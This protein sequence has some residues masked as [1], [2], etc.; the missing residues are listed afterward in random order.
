M[1]KTNLSDNTVAEAK[2]K[3]IT[4]TIDLAKAEPRLSGSGKLRAGQGYG[5]PP[6]CVRG[7]GGSLS[8]HTPA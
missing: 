1:A 3:T 7:V 6:F 2:G 4:I 5:L 8:Q